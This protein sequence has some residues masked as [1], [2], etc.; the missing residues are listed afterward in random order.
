EPAATP[1]RC[2]G[3]K[4]LVPNGTGGGQMVEASE[5][6]CKAELEDAKRTM[7]G[8]EQET[9]AASAL[10]SKAIWTA[11]GQGV[12]FAHLNQGTKEAERVW[13]DGWS[14]YPQARQRLVNAVKKSGAKNP[15]FLTGDVH[16]YWVCDVTSDA[17]NPNTP[18]IGTEFVGTSITTE[19]S[20]DRSSIMG[21]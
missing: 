15:V 18:V 12:P 13:T 3:P 6:A 14:G 19:N 11:I 21:D 8:A 7:L 17:H 4:R 5:P 10:G 2:D 1:E 20:P 16:A 9:W